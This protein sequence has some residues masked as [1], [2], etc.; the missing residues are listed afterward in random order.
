MT[1]LTWTSTN[2]TDIEDMYIKHVF[3]KK[4]FFAQQTQPKEDKISML[5]K[6]YINRDRVI[7][8]PYNKFSKSGK[9]L[10][11]QF[12]IKPTNYVMDG[13]IPYDG[14][15]YLL[16]NWGSQSVPSRYRDPTNKVIII[17]Q[18]KS[19]H[20]ASNKIKF[21]EQMKQ[22]GVRTPEFTTDVNEALDWLK[23]SEVLGRNKTGT[24]GT[25]IVFGSEEL[26]VF[27]QR[28]FWT[29][30]K[31]KKAEYRIH[32]FRDDVIDFQKKAVRKTDEHG[33]PINTSDIDFRVRNLANGFVFIRDNITPDADVF[34]QARAAVRALDLDFGAVDIIWNQHEK[35]AYV[36]EINT[37]PG[38]EGS[39]IQSYTNAIKKLKEELV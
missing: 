11:G 13:S 3:E 39:T 17:N 20:L 38:L 33:N 32:V 31:K 7:I 28:D 30:Y 26:D 12:H 9:S 15:P 22:A 16:I 14:N 35:S 1:T 21:F 25:D 36:L 23:D 8:F 29:K 34:D 6:D 2:T 19:V 4:K 10:A 37:A 27:V 18:T 24:C 5:V